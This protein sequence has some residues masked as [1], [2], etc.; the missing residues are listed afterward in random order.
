MDINNRLSILNPEE[1]AEGPESF[2]IN[3]ADVIKWLQVCV[4][5]V[6]NNDFT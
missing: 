3:E 2:D 4:F 1:F 5:F 6:Y